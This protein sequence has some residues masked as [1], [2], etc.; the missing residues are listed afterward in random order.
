M[1][2]S[3]PQPRIL[4]FGGTGR[5]GRAIRDL[6][7]GAIAP[8]R[9]EADFT[10]PDSLEKVIARNSPEIVINAA[11]FTDVEGAESR[12]SEALVVNGHAVGFIA[13]ACARHDIPLL[14]VSTDFVFPSAPSRPW[15]PDDPPRPLSAYGRSKLLGE[16]LVSL[17]GGPHLIVRTSWLFGTGGSDFVSAIFR[18]AQS[19]LHIPVVGDQV[20]GPT[21]IPALA[22]TLL[23]LSHRMIAEPGIRGIHHYCGKPWISRAQFARIILQ[24][25]GI[26][27]VQINE[28]PTHKLRQSARRPLDGRLDTTSFETTFGLGCPDWRV[29]LQHMLTGRRT[30]CDNRSS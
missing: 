19:R 2:A 24:I 3:C 8:D 18:Q 23:A 20:G 7:P 27:N 26:G 25:A 10:R 21:P 17:T 4:L 16:R 12:E 29:H 6:V 30:T 28:V 11:A 14:H 13:A 5:L 9:T 15:R 1:R 22:A